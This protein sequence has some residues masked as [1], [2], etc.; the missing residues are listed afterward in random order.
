MVSPKARLPAAVAFCSATWYFTTLD[1][2]AATKDVSLS[3]FAALT[4]SLVYLATTGGSPGMPGWGKGPPGMPCL[5]HQAL[6][7]NGQGN[8]NCSGSMS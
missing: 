5:D 3:A 8:D 2:T 1:P 4:T 7:S 6:L